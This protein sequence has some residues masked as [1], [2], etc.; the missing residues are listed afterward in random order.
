MAFGREAEAEG[1][2]NSVECLYGA[3]FKLKD[4]VS[5]HTCVKWVNCVSRHTCVN[6]VNGDHH[7]TLCCDISSLA[8]VGLFSSD[9]I[10]IGVT[11]TYYYHK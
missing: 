10:V 3:G 8:L 7:C 6:W 9:S 4:C 2:V 1:F 11:V 5:M